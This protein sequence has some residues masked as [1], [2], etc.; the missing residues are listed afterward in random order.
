MAEVRRASFG[1]ASRD[2]R[3]STHDHSE[4]TACRWE[5]DEGL[6]EKGLTQTGA[7]IVSTPQD[8][9]LR[10]AVRGVD[11]FRKVNVPILGMVQNMS[12]FVCSN[13]GHLHDIFGLDGMTPWPSLSV[14]LRLTTNRSQT[15][16]RGVR[17]HPPRRYSSPSTDL[18]RCRCRE[19]NGCGKSQQ[20]PS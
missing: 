11:L 20:S 14:L 15:Q 19:A 10:D 5:K 9:A 2:G 3:C 12:T 16:V 17:N 18:H 6:F 8:L 7:V 1:H 4:C 13:C